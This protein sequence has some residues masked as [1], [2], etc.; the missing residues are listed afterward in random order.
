MPRVEDEPWY[1]QWRE[2]LN[3]VIAAQ[4]AR[5]ASRPG[6]PEREAAERAYDAAFAAFS[7]LANQ[8]R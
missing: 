1:Q 3:R 6:T 2:A 4:M 7:A 8:L 5:D